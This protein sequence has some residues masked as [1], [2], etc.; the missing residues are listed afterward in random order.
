MD[1][2]PLIW[3]AILMLIGLA[4]L[5]LEMFVPSYGTIGF[6]AFLC[7]GGAI[8]FGFQR[9]TGYGF[10]LLTFALIAGPV[11]FAVAV[12][13]WPS[14]P[15]G[16]RILI[17]IPD[18]QEVLPNSVQRRRLQELVGKVGRAKSLMLPSG[19][20]EIEG[21]TVDAVSEGVAI[22]AG[23]LVRVVEVRAN[24]VVVRPDS[25]EPAPRRT[26]DDDLSR[27]IDSLGLDPFDDPLA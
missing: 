13:V 18:S 8:Y 23:E 5:V 7:I 9:G 25:G 22:E 2:D 17:D 6:C 10:S 12:K 1:L 16:R 24:R 3:A 20:V 15:I 14:T 21:R 11:L 4:L 26:Q 27:P 19:A